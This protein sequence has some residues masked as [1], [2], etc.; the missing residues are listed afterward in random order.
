M[1][2]CQYFG[3]QSTI[4]WKLA[5]WGLLRLEQPGK[6]ALMTA[7]ADKKGRHSKA[8]DRSCAGRCY[9]TAA[10]SA[11]V[12]VRACL[13]GCGAGEQGNPTHE[14]G[15]R[16][17]RRQPGFAVNVGS[18][19]TAAFSVGEAPHSF[20]SHPLLSNPLQSAT[21]GL[22]LLWEPAPGLGIFPPQSHSFGV[23]DARSHLSRKHGGILCGRSPAPI[24]YC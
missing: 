18:S 23:H 2:R 12:K 9:A 17:R 15:R 3:A 20:Q 19:T 6:R 8:T 7:P 13:S 1:G 21:A 4:S 10:R 11:A 24:P 16:S 14:T 22:K 5:Q